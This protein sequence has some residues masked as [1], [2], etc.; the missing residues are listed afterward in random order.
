MGILRLGIKRLARD[1]DHSHHM[2]TL[3]TSAAIAIL[4]LILLHGANRDYFNIIYFYFNG[5]KKA[6]DNKYVTN[7][8]IKHLNIGK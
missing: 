1:V 6:R 8:R 5:V 4:P 7:S 2:P 3:R